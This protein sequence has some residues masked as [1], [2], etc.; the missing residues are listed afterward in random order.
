MA[1][2]RGRSGHGRILPRDF[3][4]WERGLGGC[5]WSNPV[6][7][8]TR[9]RGLASEFVRRNDWPLADRI[10]EGRLLRLQCD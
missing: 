9:D 8:L 6:Q 3:L 2:E 7:D 4:H 5:L 1:G 10:E